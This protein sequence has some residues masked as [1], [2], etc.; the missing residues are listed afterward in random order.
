[1]VVVVVQVNPLSLEPEP[2]LRTWP[3]DSPTRSVGGG[4]T[5]EEVGPQ[6]GE[7]CRFTVVMGEQF[8]GA[9][10]YRKPWRIYRF[11]ASSPA[12]RDGWLHQLA[13]GLA[14]Y[15][16][17]GPWALRAQ[18]RSTADRRVVSATVARTLIVD[19]SGNEEVPSYS[20]GGG[21]AGGAGGGGAS[22]LWQRSYT[23]Y[24]IEYRSEANT[25]G[26]AAR[27]PNERHSATLFQHNSQEC[28]ADRAVR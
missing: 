12:E 22:A 25:H 19:G 4:A 16:K 14:A 13:R 1:M 15:R 6:L 23:R 20:E 10:G 8:V 9:G 27:T 28:A 5:D 21:A 7:D 17:Q 26:E 11:Q 18:G 3:P 2:E 24:I